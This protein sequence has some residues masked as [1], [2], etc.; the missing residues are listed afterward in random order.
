MSL[1]PAWLLVLTGFRNKQGLAVGRLDQEDSTACKVCELKRQSDVRSSSCPCP[2]SIW[3]GSKLYLRELLWRRENLQMCNSSWRMCSLLETTS[4]AFCAQRDRSSSA[5]FSTIVLPSLCGVMSDCK[6]SVH[7]Q[8]FEWL[9]GSH[10]R[11]FEKDNVLQRPFWPFPDQ[12]CHLQKEV[13]LL[14]ARPMAAASLSIC[15]PA[16]PRPVKPSFKLD[17]ALHDPVHS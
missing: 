14:G 12:Q 4:F 2:S 5:S 3:S 1:A 7:S 17:F 15:C 9:M 16:V 6:G 10:S 11:Q 8:C 13:W